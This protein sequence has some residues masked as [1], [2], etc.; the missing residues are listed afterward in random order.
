MPKNIIITVPDDETY[1]AVLA[2][3]TE[4]AAEVM[5]DRGDVEGNILFDDNYFEEDNKI[6][7]SYEQ[8]IS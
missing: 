5:N 6:K 4:D 8:D 2:F 3:L 7:L 1:D